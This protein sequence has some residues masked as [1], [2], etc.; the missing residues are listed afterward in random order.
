MDVTLLVNPK[1]STDPFNSEFDIEK[2]PNNPVSNQMYITKIMHTFHALFCF[3][4]VWY[5]YIY[6]LN[7]IHYTTSG[8]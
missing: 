3:I 1:S 8:P 2:C 4:V 7:G 5:L 6:M